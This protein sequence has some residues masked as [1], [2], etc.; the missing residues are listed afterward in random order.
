M[1]LP[2]L[3]WRHRKENL[4]KCTLTPLEGRAG[5][6]FYT[7][8]HNPLP[9]LQGYILLQIGA[10]PLTEQDKDFGLLLID[11]TWRY[12]KIM[13]K[14]LPILP[15]RSLYGFTTA[16]LRRQFDCPSPSCGLASIEAI[17]LAYHI[18]KRKTDGLL[19]LYYRKEH[20]LTLN[21]L[22]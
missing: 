21:G 1:H 16:Y 20:F 9:S 12:A 11:G 5:F 18:L 13:E 19:D 10:P 15:A 6:S 8:P 14:T 17:F 4:K 22:L 7:Y 2:T 3:I